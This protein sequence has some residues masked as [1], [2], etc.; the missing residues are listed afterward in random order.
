MGDIALQGID[1]HVSLLQED[2]WFATPTDPSHLTDLG[3]EYTANEKNGT[4][5]NECMFK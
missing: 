1:H 3:A 4:P 5:L 2:P